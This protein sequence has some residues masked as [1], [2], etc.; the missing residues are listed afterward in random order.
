MAENNYDVAIIGG[1]LAGIAASILL[2]KAGKRVILFEKHKYPF[3]RVCGEFVSNESR[4][5]LISLGLNI[6]ELELPSIDKL[7]ISTSNGGMKTFP[8]N[9]GG[10]GISRYLLD[11]KLADIA[12]SNGV[13]VMEGTAVIDLAFHDALE[14]HEISTSD[15]TYTARIAIGA[16]GKRSAIDKQMNRPFIRKPLPPGRNFTAV[17]YHVKANLPDDAIELHIFKDGYCGISKVEGEGRYCMCYLTTAA[18][19]QQFGGDIKAMEEGVLFKNPI[20]K[21]Y[22][23]HFPSL[24]AD[25]LVISQVNFSRKLPVEDHVLMTGDAAG[26]ITPLCGNGMSM[27]LHAAALAIPMVEKF[28]E[29]TLNRIELERAYTNNWNRLFSMRLKVGRALQ[30]LFF[31]ERL[32][33]YTLSALQPF[34]SLS[35]YLIGRTHGK[36]FVSK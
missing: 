15:N 33:Q 14:L 36:A 25:P 4:D 35:N 13:V 5:F 28:L 19:L 22:L 27:A 31:D 21:E 11:H 17:K 3:H 8:L 32:I 16:F 20:L 24:Y 30:H 1:G 12:K 23:T 6:E 26:L 10:F 2:A 9:L 18:S 34:P 7:N 29:G